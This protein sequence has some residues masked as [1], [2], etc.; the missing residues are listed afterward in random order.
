[1]T[2]AIGY[3]YSHADVI[4][5]G[6]GLAGLTATA[7]LTRR[8]R[9]VLVLE[10]AARLGG[11][12]AT[13]VRQG[14]QFN[15][16]PHALYRRGHAFRILRELDLPFTGRTPDA[17]NALLFAEDVFYP[18]PRGIRSLL[19]ARFLTPREKWR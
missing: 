6:G 3:P 15:L 8:G 19:G 18:L 2:E 16:G 11:R 14:A 9:T 7:L 10:G 12:A 5:V 17:S 1:M 4:V 13:H